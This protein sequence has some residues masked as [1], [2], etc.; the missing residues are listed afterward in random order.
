MHPLKLSR[1]QRD[2][3]A[4]TGALAIDSAGREVLLGLTA[5]E[6]GFVVECN[7]KKAGA[8]SAIEREKLASLIARHERARLHGMVVANAPTKNEARQG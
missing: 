6:S 1:Q 4:D 2:H 8:L 3:Y 5:E 7:T